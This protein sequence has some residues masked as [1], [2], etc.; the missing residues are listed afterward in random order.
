MQITSELKAGDTLPA[1]T[2]KPIT[3]LDLAL[4]AGAS[5][6]HNALHIDIDAARA[7]G[8]EDVFAQGMLPMAYLARCLTDWL[9]Q[10]RLRSYGVRFA[11]IT[12]L[13]ERLTCT[14][15]VAEII[16]RAGTPCARLDLTA[17]NES[18]EIKLKGEA[19]VA[20]KPTH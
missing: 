11:A 7:A 19:V 17:A 4:F 15:T 9:P 12:Q 2:T 5:G 16:D 14:G 3:R 10:S 18:G 1:L 8:M 13:H 20:L 6:D